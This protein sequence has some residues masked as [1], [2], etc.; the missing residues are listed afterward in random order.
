MRNLGRP[1]NA[2]FI[3]IG[4]EA[5]KQ[6][7]G[8]SEEKILD[9]FY[10]PPTEFSRE[11]EKKKLGMA[12]G[13]ALYIPGLMPNFSSKLTN[14]N[15]KNL[16]SAIICLEDSVSDFELIDAENNIINELQLIEQNYEN[17]IIDINN[18]P[19]LFLRIRSVQHFEKIA[20]IL[21]NTM[22]LFTGI[23]FPKCTS[24]NA[25]SFFLCLQEINHQYSIHLYA[26]PILETKEIIYA[27]SR[28]EEL[29][30]LYRLF[31]QFEDLILTIRVGATDFSSLFGL[32]R[33]ANRTIYDL[34]LIT[35]CLTAILNTFNRQ[36]D[37]FIISG[38]VFEYFEP[39]PQTKLQLGTNSIEMTLWNEA[40][41]DAFNGF[42]GKTCIHPSQ[43]DIVN[44]TY[45][46]SKELYEDASLIIGNHAESN[47]VLR[48]PT[49]N[50]MNEVKPHYN[51]ALKTLAQA[52]IYG[53]LKENVTTF[54]FLQYIKN[55]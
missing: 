11:L 40:Q 51:W 26:L 12:M 44:A 22:R 25:K 1:N 23:V 7:R 43:I 18:L 8:V 17:K 4:V 39:H 24:S 35:N 42:N 9:F 33:P 27:E 55:I 38:P 37:N 54:D 19:L 45:V 52:E 29:S 15:L 10:A 53:V 6:F 2:F 21:G 30:N 14:N 36:V 13:A 3:F 46:V 20:T 41:L 16:T 5:M 32:R 34:N 28:A 50:K 31:K 48:S 49:R 47:G